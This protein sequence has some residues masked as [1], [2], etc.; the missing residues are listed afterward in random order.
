MD[1]TTLYGNKI[2]TIRTDADNGLRITDTI[3][4]ITEGYVK[5]EDCPLCQAVL[6]GMA[7]AITVSSLQDNKKIRTATLPSSQQI[8]RYE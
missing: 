1:N 8:P 2:Y 4:A 6:S 7:E 5:K 3:N